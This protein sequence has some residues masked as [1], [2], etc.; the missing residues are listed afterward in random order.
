MNA[1]YEIYNESRHVF[2]SRSN[3]ILMKLKVVNSTD[4]LLAIVT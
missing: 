1:Q 2:M 3:L 4:T